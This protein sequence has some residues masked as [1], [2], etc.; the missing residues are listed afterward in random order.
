MIA[1]AV[2]VLRYKEP[3]LERPF[4]VKFLPL[5]SVLGIGFNIFLMLYVRK[6]TWIAF[7][8]WSGLGIIVYFLYSKRN[9][10]LNEWEAEQ[11]RLAKTDHT[12]K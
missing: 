2:L 7:L 8:I 5:V 4:R 11:E 10:K 9:S 1:L 6:E 12:E 3:D